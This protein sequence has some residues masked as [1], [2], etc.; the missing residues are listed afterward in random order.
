MGK[1]ILTREKLLEGAKHV[2]PDSRFWYRCKY[3]P[4]P[5]EDSSETTKKE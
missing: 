2:G 5:K 4:V 3:D 1:Y